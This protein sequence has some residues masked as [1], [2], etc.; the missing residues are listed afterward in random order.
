M[1]EIPAPYGP[2]HKKSDLERIAHFMNGFLGVE[3]LY[4]IPC[5]KKFENK[6]YDDLDKDEQNEW[7][8]YTFAAVFRDASQGTAGHLG[9]PLKVVELNLIKRRLINFFFKT[10]IEFHGD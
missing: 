4:D 6:K 8:E 5:L 9:R 1:S 3:M 10:N 2:H 7:F